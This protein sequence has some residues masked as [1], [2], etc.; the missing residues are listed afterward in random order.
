MRVRQ[1][2]FTVFELMIVV[3]IIGILATA[4]V[5]I[6][7]GYVQEARLNEAK[8]YMLDIAARERIYK[9]RNG[10]YCCSGSGLDETVMSAGL[11]VDLTTTGN[12]CFVVICR[13]STL[14]TT[15]TTTAFAAASEAGDP[16]VEFEVWAIL[17]QTSTTTV[18]GPQSSTCTMP[19]TKRPP[20]GWVA[21][22]TSG[23]AARQGRAIV[24]R[25][26]P[27]PNGRDAV[28]GANS[29]KFSWAE[30]MSLTHALTP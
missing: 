12:F 13:D 20:T 30:G 3:T 5:P 23:L 27:P 9:L 2:G 14:C 29:V 11:G 21:A 16:T 18:A 15:P 25:Y 22:S 17:R 4:A 1:R 6:F 8:P 10:T 24:F 19:T 28:S 7:H 26:P